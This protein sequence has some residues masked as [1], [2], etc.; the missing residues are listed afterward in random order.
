MWL[1]E[2]FAAEGP[3]FDRF[4]SGGKGGKKK[5]GRKEHSEQV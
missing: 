5:G 2:R 3:R 1:I 4:Q